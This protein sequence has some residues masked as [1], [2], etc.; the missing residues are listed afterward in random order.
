L[1]L[2]CERLGIV[3]RLGALGGVGPLKRGVRRHGALAIRSSVEETRTCHVVRQ[4][5]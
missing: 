2:G 1:H 4:V 5:A 3:G